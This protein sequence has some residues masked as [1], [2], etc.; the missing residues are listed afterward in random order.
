M[1]KSRT[2]RLVAIGVVLFTSLWVYRSTRS[3]AGTYAIAEIGNL[4]LDVEVSGTL[5]ATDSSQVGPPLVEH[6]HRFKISMM[7]P[8]GDSVTEGQPILAFDTS[9][10]MDRLRQ[11]RNEIAEAGT[12]VK[13]EEVALSVQNA[14]DSLAMAEAQAR[15]RKARMA[16]SR[17][18]KLFASIERDEAALDLAMAELEVERL[19]RRIAFS[20]AATESKIDALRTDLERTQSETD[21]VEQA[22]ESMV[23]KAPRDGVVTYTVNWR[24]EKKKVGDTCYRRETVLEIPDL[25]K[26]MGDGEVEEALSGRISEGQG[27][28]F[29]LDAHQDSTYRGSVTRV[30]RAV[31]EKSWRNPLKIVR[32]EIGLEATDPDR[33]RPG[34]RFRGSIEVERK[35]NVLLIPVDAV[36]ASPTGPSARVTRLGRTSVV[37][38]SVGESDGKSIEVISGLEEGDRILT[39][40][41]TV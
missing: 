41:Q 26:M 36:F 25:T 9:E 21:R 35:D 13:K 24:N 12:K 11:H 1:M 16:D 31:E 33:M 20:K 29:H 28:E 3:G 22:I 5:R 30:V 14:D 10:L 15:L 27:V 4:V 2:A 39:A 6:L 18:S 34:M 7:A 8:E 32:I 19:T 38:L 40:R 37:P 17:P 23:R